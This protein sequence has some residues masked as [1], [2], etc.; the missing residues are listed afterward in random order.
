MRAWLQALNKPPITILCPPAKAF[1]MIPTITISAKK[2]R[3]SPNY[4][5]STCLPCRC[6]GGHLS[7]GNISCLC[8]PLFCKGSIYLCRIV[9]LCVCVHKLHATSCDLLSLPIPS[10]LLL[11]SV[12]FFV[13][14]PMDMG[15]FFLEAGLSDAAEDAREVLGLPPPSFS[16]VLWGYTQW[17]TYDITR[18]SSAPSIHVKNMLMFATPAGL[19]FLFLICISMAD[20]PHCRLRSDN[21]CQAHGN[22]SEREGLPLLGFSHSFSIETLND[23]SW[24]P[25]L[26][27][28]AGSVC[29][30]ESAFTITKSAISL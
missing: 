24:I 22:N 5:A 26:E 3:Q 7:H 11:P 13:I 6:C 18:F 16:I 2:Q 20:L 15:F 21:A 12:G 4:P 29:C 17:D 30:G 23:H 27:T 14:T 1:P 9:R 10:P 8:P 28:C 19:L 25:Q